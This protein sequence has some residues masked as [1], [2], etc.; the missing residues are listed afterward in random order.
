MKSTWV[1]PFQDLEANSRK[2]RVS[3][4]SLPGTECLIWSIWGPPL[5]AP[6]RNAQVVQRSLCESGSIQQIQ[7]PH[8]LS[9][10]STADRLQS[11]AVS[12]IAAFG[13]QFTK[14]WPLTTSITP[15][16]VLW[17]CQNYVYS[18]IE[19]YSFKKSTDQIHYSLQQHL[20]AF[21]ELGLRHSK[22]WHLV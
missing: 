2:D 18:Y 4:V 8:C 16:Y 20:K 3:T 14:L 22:A 19:K 6:G 9:R 1:K 15:V 17:S 11:D 7:S 10:S 13:V 5:C 21:S 12:S